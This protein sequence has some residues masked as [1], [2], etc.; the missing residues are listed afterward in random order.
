MSPQLV[1]DLADDV[2]FAH[3]V[4][5][6]REDVAEGGFGDR[7]GAAHRSGLVFGLDRS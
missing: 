1:V 6:L 3:A 4:H 5:E 7:A 2:E